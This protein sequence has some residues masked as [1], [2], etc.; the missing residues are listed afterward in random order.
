MSLE[1]ETI[2]LTAHFDRY[3]AWARDWVANHDDAVSLAQFFVDRLEA[4]PE[5]EGLANFAILGLLTGMID[6]S[7]EVLASDVPNN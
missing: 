7:N 4:E 3:R 1:R 2:A 5:N 6:A